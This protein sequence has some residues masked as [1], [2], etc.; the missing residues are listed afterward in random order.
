MLCCPVKYCNSIKSHG[1]VEMRK[2]DSIFFL[3]INHWQKPENNIWYS[4]APLGKNEIGKFMVTAVKWAGIAGNNTKPFSEKNLQMTWTLLCEHY[5][6]YPF[7]LFDFLYFI[8]NQHVVFSFVHNNSLKKVF[9][10]T[11]CSTKTKVCILNWNKLFFLKI[12]LSVA[13]A[14]KIVSLTFIRF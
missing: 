9:S 2:P 7:W 4:K 14:T 13:T 6:L 1:T 10:I 8:S 5:H 11:L 12:L 3:T